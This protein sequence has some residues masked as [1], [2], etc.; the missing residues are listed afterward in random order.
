MGEGKGEV[1]D[2]F[3]F[4]TMDTDS[5]RLK[6]YMQTHLEISHQSN[7]FPLDPRPGEPVTLTITVG[8]DQDVKDAWVYYSTD[9]KDPEVN[10]ENIIHG[11]LKPMQWVKVEWDDLTW[12]Y[13]HT[14]SCTLPGQPDQTVVRYRICF[15]TFSGDLI[16][17]DKGT[18][19]AY[20][21]DE[22]SEPLWVKDAVIYHIM[23]DRFSTQPGKDWNK[24]DSI[25]DIY[26][27]NLQGIQNRL[28]YLENLGIN[29][30][31]LS[32]I[33]P[34]DNHHR[35]NATDYFEIDPVIGSKKD[36][37][38]LLDDVHRR[39]MRLIIDFVPN[40]WSDQHPTFRQAISDPESPYRDWYTFSHYPDQYD[41]FFDI[42]V[43]PKINL[44]NA[45]ARK[46]IIDS[47]CYWLE[48]GVDGLRL[49]Y[50]IGPT[51][52]FW[53]DFRLATRRVNPDCWTIG[54][55][56]DSINA[57]ATFEGLL[58]GCLD[59]VLLEALRQTFA[60][61][62]WSAEKFTSFLRGHQ[63]MFHRDFSRP[64]FLDNHDMDR[65]LWGARNNKQALKLAALCQF[66][67]RN[68]PMI[69]YGT[70]VGLTQNKGTREFRGG[71]G[72]LE[73]A[74]L[75]M[76]WNDSQDAELND[77]Y[78]SLISLRKNESS[79]R[80]GNWELVLEKK[81]CFCYS[82]QDAGSKLF[83]LF[84]ISQTSQQIEI[85]FSWSTVVFSTQKE[86]VGE[87]RMKNRIDLAPVSGLILH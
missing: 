38:N 45:G 34:A 77:Y 14:F 61:H 79:L 51:P 82:R 26:G 35:Y 53:A 8:Q 66:T 15:K 59:F 55:V 4:G 48:F 74:R 56:V 25:Q 67:L 60:T 6:H 7:R 10:E 64:C 40:H 11:F 85:P 30:L 3:I 17:A 9:G 69:Y 47:A 31:Y 37:K 73:E 46:H 20:A 50:A 5:L 24:V 68:C 75:P 29:V 49:D 83:C 18:Y 72:L 13:V 44:R 86:R 81:E 62:V 21:V 78:R 12:G 19:Y 54:E 87:K 16:Y 57:Q 33:F 36:F 39:G 22:Y 41:R 76:P 2:D 71:F 43:M 42:G 27:G 32:P 1:M 52:D 70:E 84:N 65:F 23:I 80:Y 58:D 28:D 63:A